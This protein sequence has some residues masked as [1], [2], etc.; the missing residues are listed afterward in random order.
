MRD[1]VRHEVAVLFVADTRIKAHV[2]LHENVAA[3]Q[4]RPDGNAEHIRPRHRIQHE[5]V[6]HVTEHGDVKPRKP[7]RSFPIVVEP[8]EAAEHE[9]R[10]VRFARF[11]H[12]LK[13]VFRD[14]VVGI[15]EQDVLALRRFD[16]D[17]ARDRN[18][19]VF[20]VNDAEARILRRRLV[21]DRA[22]AVLRPVVDKNGFPVLIRLRRDRFQAKTEIVFNVVYRNDD[23]DQRLILFHIAPSCSFYFL[24]PSVRFSAINGSYSA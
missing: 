21:A 1:H 9:I 17:V 6:A 24:I 20:L 10:A 5:V 23:A 13:I 19:A 18:A 12:F 2:V 14:E 4:L 3:E 7:V 8:F 16:T 22:A 15:D 11:D